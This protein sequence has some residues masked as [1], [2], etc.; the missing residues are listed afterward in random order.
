M[1]ETVPSHTRVDKTGRYKC[2]LCC[3]D[4]NSAE[5]LSTHNRLEHSGNVHSPAGIG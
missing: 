5:E 4:F 2:K 3:I 1:F